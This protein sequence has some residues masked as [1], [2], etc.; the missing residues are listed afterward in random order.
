MYRSFVFEHY[1]YSQET[2]EVTFE[3][4]FDGAR[5]FREVVRLTPSDM[6][7]EALL[8]EAL[9]L[10][11]ILCGISYYKTFP[12]AEFSFRSITL[13][14]AQAAFFTEVYRDGLSQF[15]Y[16]NHLTPGVVGVFTGSSDARPSPRSY[17]GDGSLVLQSGGKDS[18]LLAAMLRNNDQPFTPWYISSSGSMPKVIAQLSE[19]AV[20]HVR[21]IDA[22]ALK[23][24][25]AD[26]GRNGHV[27]ITYILASFAIIDAVLTGKRDILLSIGHEG[28]EP[29]AY[30]DD[31]AIRHQWAKTWHAEQLLALYVADYLSPDIR[32]GSPLRKYSELK[33][34]ELFVQHAWGSYAALFS[35]CN[36]ANYKQGQLNE[37]LTWCGECAKCANS[38]L[39]F[40]A[41]VQPDELMPIFGDKNL[42]ESSSLEDD[43]KGL[44]GI[45]DVVKPF[46]CVSDVD[47][48][49]KAY[50]LALA[51][52]YGPLPFNVPQSDFNKDYEYPAQ[53]WV[54]NIVR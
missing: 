36:V 35:S 41:F 17:D 27:P 24:A 26:G 21:R 30:I 40:A 22:A 16:E 49:R 12:T 34:V 47:E 48:L 8:D 19:D 10:A 4:S 54:N 44:L 18:L 32:I 50:E 43:F 39:L 29:H 42:F 37:Q 33:I 3:Y 11:F 31:Y 38:Y 9:K 52:G 14:P 25:E 1:S 20:C 53:G 2:G 23:Q 7:D 45:D 6:Y 51:N 46:E 5:K 13:T 15:V 28:D